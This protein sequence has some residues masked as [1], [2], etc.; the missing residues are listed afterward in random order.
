MGS[1]TISF[2]GA[3]VK[4]KREEVMF[5]ITLERSMSGVMSQVAAAPMHFT[6]S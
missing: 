1:F 4:A 3:L 5:L 2:V 6:L